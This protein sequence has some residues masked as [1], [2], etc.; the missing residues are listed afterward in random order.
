MVHQLINVPIKPCY[1]PIK[2]KIFDQALSIKKDEF[3]SY[4]CLVLSV[5][6][7]RNIFLREVYKFIEIFS[8]FCQT[9]NYSNSMQQVK[10]LSRNMVETNLAR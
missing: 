6:R 4:T 1:L 8:I 3:D 5:Q 7:M 9:A 10:R 2:T